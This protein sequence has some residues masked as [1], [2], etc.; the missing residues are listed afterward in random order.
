MLW[1]QGDIYVAAIPKLPRKVQPR[2]RTCRQA[3]AW[4]AGFD[5]PE[6]Y[7]PVVET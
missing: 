3:A 1:R 5:D 7:R 2:T 6:K 4:M